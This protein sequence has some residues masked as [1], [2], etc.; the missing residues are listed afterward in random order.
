MAGG[1]SN[2]KPAKGTL[3]LPIPTFRRVANRITC[4]STVSLTSIHASPNEIRPINDEIEAAS[5]AFYRATES[6]SVEE[7]LHLAGWAFHFPMSPIGV[8]LHF[9]QELDEIGTNLYV[10]AAN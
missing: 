9:L 3:N 7:G 6:I 1:L 8:K 2:S 5:G 10:T 4:I